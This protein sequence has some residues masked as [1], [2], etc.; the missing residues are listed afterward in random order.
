MKV[1]SRD[2][3]KLTSALNSLDNIDQRLRQ[4]SFSQGNLRPRMAIGDSTKHSVPDLKDAESN[5]DEGSPLDSGKYRGMKFIDIIKVA[6]KMEADAIE[7][8]LALIEKS[9]EKY[10]KTFVEIAND[11]ND[12]SQLYSGIVNELE[13]K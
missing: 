3:I 7:I 9:P 8:G 5:V 1:S 11:E 12:H 4:K 13:G 10:K 2:R 6:L